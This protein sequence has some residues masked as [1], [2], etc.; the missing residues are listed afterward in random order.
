MSTQTE[1]TPDGLCEQLLDYAYGELEGEAKAAFETHLG[2]CAKCQ[3][4]LAD[5]KRVRGAVKAAIPQVEPPAASLGGLHAQLMHAAAQ[6]AKA[7]GAPKGKL[8]RFARKVATHPAYAMAAMFAVIVTAV[9]VQWSRG[10]LLMPAPEAA[11]AAEAP[12]PASPAQAPPPPLAA[13]ES[14]P[15]PAAKGAGGVEKKKVVASKEEALRDL[16]QV[17]PK[18]RREA[19]AGDVAK[20]KAKRAEADDL[21]SKPKDAALKGLLDAKAGD[22][23]AERRQSGGLGGRALGGSNATWNA[24]PSALTGDAPSA[25]PRV[26]PATQPG[27]RSSAPAPQAAEPAPAS[28]PPARQQSAPAYGGA[29]R[30]PQ[31]P[32]LQASAPSYAQR[33]VEGARK[34]AEALAMAGQCQAAERLF[35]QLKKQYP[36]F[37]LTQKEQLNMVRCYRVTGRTDEALQ[38]LENLKRDKAAA[39][40]LLKLEEEALSRDRRPAKAAVPAETEQRAQKPAK[41]KPRPAEADRP[42]APAAAPAERQAY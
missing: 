33:D 37:T 35:D 6:Q 4:E 34:K 24:D 32:L 28:G 29:Q 21:E 18:M 13:P 31:Q 36:G 27:L 22:D 25:S 42:A 40:S 15:A 41:A 30:A 39:S 20:R 3:A 19:P 5:L 10:K 12:A 8:L 38:R 16:D 17:R 2:S 9:G 11:P 23:L 1:H 26:V 7:T 14:E